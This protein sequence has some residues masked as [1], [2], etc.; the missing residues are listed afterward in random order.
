[1]ARPIGVFLRRLGSTGV[2]TSC[3]GLGG[4]HTGSPE[5][6]NLEAISL[7]RAAVDEGVNFFDNC[8]D[9]HNGVLLKSKVVTKWFGGDRPCILTD[10]QER[11]NGNN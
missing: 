4:S 10:R 1:M 2:S 9:H 6:G 3:L 7:M 8:W 5:I 11:L